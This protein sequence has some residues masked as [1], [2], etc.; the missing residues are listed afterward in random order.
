MAKKTPKGFDPS[1]IDTVIDDVKALSQPAQKLVVDI[2]GLLSGKAK[3]GATPQPKG[4]PTDDECDCG[5]CLE[6]AY[7]CALHSLVA[8][9]KAQDALEAEAE[10]A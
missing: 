5:E 9:C 4:C 2:V 8:I 7:C 6:C 1:M 3:M 10:D